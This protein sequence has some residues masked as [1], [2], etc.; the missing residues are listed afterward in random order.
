MP[1]QILRLPQLLGW[2]N[3]SRS[4]L[5]SEIASG[6]FP[7][8]LKLGARAIGWRHSDVQA[9]LDSRSRTEDAR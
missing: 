7:A 4:W 1:D 9:W 6:R 2:L 8:P 3:M 5:Y